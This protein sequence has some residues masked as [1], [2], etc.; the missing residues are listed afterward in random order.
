MG[1]RAA[2]LPFALLLA[3]SPAAATALPPAYADDAEPALPVWL[4]GEVGAGTLPAPGSFRPRGRLLYR[5]HGL[6]AVREAMEPGIAP[7]LPRGLEWLAF[8]TP[9]GAG[10]LRVYLRDIQAPATSTRSAARA[11]SLRSLLGVTPE[12]LIESGRAGGPLELPLPTAADL[13]DEAP[14]GP[15]PPHVVPE[16]ATAALVLLGLALLCAAGARPT[17]ARAP[18]R[19]ARLR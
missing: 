4:A 14:A 2:L 16:P 18:A 8:D 10:G 1:P 19:R 7:P 17:P 11:V 3:A 6:A 9:P 13:E 15:A 5:A 12:I